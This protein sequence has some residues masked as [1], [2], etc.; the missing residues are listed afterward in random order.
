MK[1]TI[2]TIDHSKQRYN[3]IGDWQWDGDNL[4]IKVSKMGDTRKEFLVALHELVEVFLCKNDGVTEEQVDEFDLS[5]P[6][7]HEPGDSIKAPYH[8]QHNLALDIE[9]L[10]MHALGVNQEEYENLME[11]LQDKRDASKG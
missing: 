10:V 3:T 1:I 2:E 9:S 11:D 7:L 4:N 6:E 8:K 5:H